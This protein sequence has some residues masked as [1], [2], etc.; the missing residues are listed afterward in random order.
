LRVIQINEQR[1]ALTGFRPEN[2]VEETSEIKG[3]FGLLLLV[4]HGVP[5]PRTKLYEQNKSLP[6]A[7]LP[8]PVIR[9]KPAEGAKVLP[10]AKGTLL[11]TFCQLGS[12]VNDLALSGGHPNREKVCAEL[13]EQD[14]DTR[15]LFPGSGS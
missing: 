2:L 9:I 1:N 6:C 7:A 10:T 13:S 15:K 11:P 4:R 3:R 8:F 14:R 5:A 12:R